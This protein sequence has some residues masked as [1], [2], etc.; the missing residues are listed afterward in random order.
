MNPFRSLVALV[1]VLG[2]LLSGLAPAASAQ[3]SGVPE[4]KLEKYTLAN[5]LQVIFHQDMKL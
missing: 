3:Q 4:I 1:F 5:G 2:L